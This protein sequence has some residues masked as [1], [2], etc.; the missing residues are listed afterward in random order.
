MGRNRIELIAQSVHCLMS[1]LLVEFVATWR[2]HWNC[3]SHCAPMT[4]RV[5][6]AEQL[7]F[8]TGVQMNGQIGVRL[9]RTAV[10][11]V[12]CVLLSWL[13]RLAPRFTSQTKSI[14]CTF[15]RPRF[16]WLMQSLLQG[17]L[18]TRKTAWTL[19]CSSHCTK[20]ASE[21]VEN[22]TLFTRFEL[23]LSIKVCQSN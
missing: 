6:G 5:Q 3:Y 13:R 22:M 10:Y 1:C 17:K 7:P 11:T 18:T 15:V 20:M 2:R 4:Q 23:S 19:N 12:C 21:Y 9:M 14:A 8:V 16:T